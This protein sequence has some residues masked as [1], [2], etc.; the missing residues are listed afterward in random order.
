M[1]CN[2]CNGQL[3]KSLDKIGMDEEGDCIACKWSGYDDAR[4]NAYGCPSCICGSPNQEHGK[5]SKLLEEAK[6]F[7]RNKG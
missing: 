4:F 1:L 7:L 3:P 6:K 5:M 2:F